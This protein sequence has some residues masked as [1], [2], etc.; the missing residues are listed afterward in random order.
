MLSALGRFPGPLSVELAYR[1]FG[2]VGRSA[3][4]HSRDS[5]VHNAASV[6][7]LRIGGERVSSY[8]WGSGPEVVLLVH[9]W[10]SR[11]SALSA[12]VSTLERPERTVIA[13][14]APANGASSGRKVTALDYA[15]VIDA[16]FQQHGPFEVIVAHSF[17]TLATFLAVNQGVRTSSIVSIAG[18]HSGERLVDAFASQVGLAPSMVPRLKDRLAGGPFRRLPDPWHALVSELHWPAAEI[19]L[20]VVCDDGDRVVDP[21]ESARIVQA[22]R[23]RLVAMTTQGLG[24]SRILR[25]PRVLAAVSEFVGDPVTVERRLR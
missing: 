1:V 6:S 25:D 24:H 10:H 23:G 22:H 8:A 19:P 12:L 18:V 16:F 3:S 15:D 21:S 17:G 5:A 13:F 7:A 14:D 11:A 20:L 4:V 2:R 9:G